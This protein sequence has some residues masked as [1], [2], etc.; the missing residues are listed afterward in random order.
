MHEANFPGRNSRIYGEVDRSCCP[1]SEQRS[2]QGSYEMSSICFGNSAWSRPLTDSRQFRHNIKCSFWSKHLWYLYIHSHSSLFVLLQFP[3]QVL[4]FYRH[5]HAHPPRREPC[6]LFI[7]HRH[8]RI[9]SFQQGHINSLC[10]QVLHCLLCLLA[11]SKQI[12][13]RIVRRRSGEVSTDAVSER[14]GSDS[15][16]LGR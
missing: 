16:G 11:T 9:V 1:L 8:S 14:R 15:F 5:L 6:P 2:A 7:F 13:P 10:T 3:C 12:L 4:E